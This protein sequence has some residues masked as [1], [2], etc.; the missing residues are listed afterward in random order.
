MFMD[1]V[2]NFSFDK[3]AKMD[4]YKPKV[5]GLLK[6]TMEILASLAHSK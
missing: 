1:T 5:Q 6:F 4:A 2:N 3:K